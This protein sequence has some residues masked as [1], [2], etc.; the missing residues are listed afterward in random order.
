LSVLR[1][2]TVLTVLVSAALVVGVVSPAY[3]G[4]PVPPSPTHQPR[5][6]PPLPVKPGKV[7]AP[8]SGATD[9]GAAATDLVAKPSAPAVQFGSP[10]ST[11]S[12]NPATSTPISYGSNDIIFKNTD[13]S[14]TKEVSPTQINVKHGDGSWGPAQT[15]MS[16]DSTTGGY[17]V[18]N[19]PLNPKFAGAV[20]GGSG[21]T[22]DSNSHPVTI[23][24][25]GAAPVAAARPSKALRPGGDA[26]SELVYPGVHSGQDLHYQVGASEVKETVVLNSVPSASDSSWTWQVHAPGLNLVQDAMGVEELVDSAGVAQYNLPTPVMWDSSAVAGQSEPVVT[27]VPTTYVQDAPG[28]WLVTMTP[29]RSWLTDPSRVYPVSIDPP[30]S[31]N[32]NSM[33]AYKSDGI[34]SSGVT[35]VGNP[36]QSTTVYWRTVVCYNYAAIFGSEM[37]SAYI[38]ASYVTGNGATTSY[39]GGAY[40]ATAFAYSGGTPTY[41]SAFTLNPSGAASDAPLGSEIQ[42]LVNQQSAGTCFQLRGYEVPHVYSYRGVTTA[43]YM[44]YEAKPALT[45]PTPTGGTVASIM[46]TLSVSATDPSGAPQNYRFEVSTN[47]NPDTTPVWDSGYATSS[48]YMQVP[49]GTLTAGTTYYWKA[50]VTDEYGAVSASPVGS[51]IAN[52]PGTI[53]QTNSTPTDRAV[54]ASLTPTLSVPTA[55]IPVGPTYSY[56]F[57]LTTGTDGISGQVVS[58][59]ILSF[60]SSGRLTWQVPPSVLQDGGSYSWTV[61]VE[62]SHDNYWTWVNHFTVSLR[63]TNPGPAPTDGAGP[64]T[65]NLANGNVAAS[66]ASPTVSTLGGAMGLSFNYNSEAA[67]NGGLTGTYYNAIASGTTTPVFTFPATTPSLLQRTDSQLQFDWSTAPPV[68]GFPSHN[69]LAQWT[70]FVTPPA[71]GSYTYGFLVNDTASLYLG[72]TLNLNRTSPT[73]GSVVWGSATTM[74][75]GP[76]TVKVQYTDAA[77]AAQLQLWVKYTN[78]GGTLVSEIVPATWFTKTIPTLP[79]GWSGSQP[80]LGSAAGYVSAQNSGGSITFTDTSGGTHT[81]TLNPGASAGYTPPAGEHGIVSV[82]SG[83]I[84]LTDDAGTVYVFNSAGLLLSIT[85]PADEAKPAEPVPSYNANG[86]LQTISDPLSTNGAPTPTYSRQVVFTYATASNTSGTGVCVL[87]AVST[88]LEVTPLGYLCA[89]GYPDGTST[90]LYFDTNGQ[91]AEDVDP[92]GAITNFGYTQQTTGP[93]AGQFLLTTIRNPLENDW[94]ANNSTPASALQETTIQYDSYGRAYTVTLPAPD[95]ATAS[96]QPA[97]TYY[98]SSATA[99]PPAPGATGTGWVSEA[100]LSPSSTAPADGYARTVTYNSALQ[101]LTDTS[102]M[103]F[104]S[105]QT[106][107]NSDDLLTSVNPQGIES[108]TTY[109]SQNR[110]TDSYGPAPSTCFVGQIP[111]GTCAIAAAHSTVSYD[112]GLQGLNEIFYGNPNL[113]GVPVAFGLQPGT[114]AQTWNGTTPPASGVPATGFS[115]EYNGTITF[116][117]AGTYTITST[118]T[119]GASVYIADILTVNGWTVAGAHTGTYVATAGQVAR[120]R[121]E[122]RDV[123]GAGNLTLAWTPQGGSTATVPAA[124]LS[125]DYSLTT[126]THIA[127]GTATGT[128]SAQVPAGNTATTYGSSPWLGQVASISVDPAGLNL[129]STAT[130]ETSNTLYNRQLASAKP[131]GSTT[132]TATSTTDSYYGATGTAGANAGASGS[133]CVAATTPQY[134]MLASTTGPGPASGVAAVTKYVYDLLG[135]VVGVLEPGD[136]V[137]T[138]A[139]YDS[140]GRVSTIDLPAYGGNS[141]RLETYTY[142]MMDNGPSIQVSDAVTTNVSEWTGTIETDTD[143]LGEPINYIDTSGIQTQN[144][145]NQLG[146]LT[147]SVANNGSHPVTLGYSYDVDGRETQETVA[148]TDVNGNWSPAVDEAD[149]TY[150]GD[151]LASI[152]Y[153]GNSATTALTPTYGPT[154]AVV[155]DAWT[156][157]SGQNGVTD[158]NTLSQ[159]G[160]VMQDQIRDAGA[161]LPYTSSYTYD[162]AG[163]LTG[164]TVPDNTLAYGFGATTVAACGS[165]ADL[166]A[167]ENGNRAS[168]SDTTTGGTSASTTPATVSSCYDN[169]DRLISDAVGGAPAGASP[170]LATSLA[171]TGSTPNLSYDVH[172]STTQIADDHWT[173][174]ETGRLEKVVT[175][176][177]ETDYSTNSEGRVM[178]SSTTT[179][180]STL[181][182]QYQYTDSGVQF[183]DTWNPGTFI[184]TFEANISL[185]G[186]VTASLLDA[187]YG[188]SSP[189]LSQVWSYP[190]LHGDDIVTTNG[191]GTRTGSLALYDPFGNNI[192][193]TTG[194]IGSVAANNIDLSNGSGPT[195]SFGWEGSHGKQYQHTADIATIEMGARQ[196]VPILGRF[197]S[198]DPVSGGNAND[199]NYPNDPINGSDLS[200]DMGTA[201]QLAGFSGL[202]YKMIV[203]VTCFRNGCTTTVTRARASSKG[204]TTSTGRPGQSSYT[205]AQG[206]KD[207]LSFAYGA[208]VVSTVAGAA[209]F[210]PV[211]APVAKPVALLSGIVST[212]IYC[213]HGETIDCEIGGIATASG[214]GGFALKGVLGLR[215]FGLTSGAGEASEGIGNIMATWWNAA[216]LIHG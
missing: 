163:R 164:A 102:A 5:I 14:E 172:G 122:Y 129:T 79:G 114:I 40:V 211:L 111:S 43:L 213:S 9:E 41:L 135:R 146:E 159:S 115:I 168:Y 94:L 144:S 89:I 110:P 36:N 207:A 147:Q 137:W 188:G 98:Y 107:D 113:A 205:M 138:C 84:N 152:A 66:F 116:P 150:T 141:D 17:K 183:Q 125:P 59:P 67:S 93:T 49:R 199:Y 192:D 70:G 180:T 64:V 155:E 198:V 80:L 196:Y 22:V 78:S 130:Y 57:R 203:S 81:Y 131:A 133:N 182:T 32:G 60:P 24:L 139:T 16:A 105:T 7:V 61:L 103:G 38:G 124:D 75:A 54:V 86:Q 31:E 27:N 134:G 151:R 179:G 37:T 169:A 177:S 26:S 201:M 95:G 83:N 118:A 88:G 12:F 1:R 153:P 157:A 4:G 127:D 208:G 6:V 214:L 184:D 206:N 154:G 11:S 197:L 30:I 187:N 204:H 166:L 77:D 29:D 171:S 68:P 158:T 161:T 120:I 34:T 123:T 82:T 58:S 47:A 46:P 176:A 19:N 145:Y 173:Y 42:S 117:T 162:A 185:P 194:L 92:G 87:P 149:L 189:S 210:I 160:R 186:G 72:G 100:G 65:V 35:N 215:M 51:F 112:G 15:S 71:A 190:D 2:N 8:K 104:T 195:S 193:P 170:L 200:G 212:G 52:T 119:G 74:A 48:S 121:I 73:G 209:S 140:R 62:D 165:Q 33:V 55:A 136:S 56:Q 90:N 126:G 18:L 20:G 106:W 128:A 45:A 175:N 97:K 21:F 202:S 91:L 96:T 108:S 143:L 178:Q 142:T 85:S 3:A 101:K 156:F 39:T 69:F 44:N 132:S 76:T 13:G 10:A 181:V 148:S 63:V 25:V 191:N 53:S 109:D 28:D 174:D 50:Y 23:S 167:G 99:V 216:G